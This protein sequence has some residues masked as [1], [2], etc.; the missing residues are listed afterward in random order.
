[1][2]RGPRARAAPGRAHALLTRRAEGGLVGSVRAPV[3]RPSGADDLCRQFP[4]GGGRRGA[5]GVNVLPDDR[6]EEFVQRFV[7]A[8]G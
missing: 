2:G 5:A 6:Y 8:F 7:D 1:M 3:D 4:T